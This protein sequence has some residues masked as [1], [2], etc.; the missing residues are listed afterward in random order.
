MIRLLGTEPIKPSALIVTPQCA[1][2]TKWSLK[3]SGG[4][5]GGSIGSM[6]PPILK[7]CLREYLASKFVQM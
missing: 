3:F 2:T 4:S 7:G 5:R 1:V 6:E